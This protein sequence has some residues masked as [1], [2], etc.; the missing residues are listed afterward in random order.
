MSPRGRPVWSRLASPGRSAPVIG[1]RVAVAAFPDA[2]SPRPRPSSA[3]GRASRCMP[4]TAGHAPVR[5]R[6]TI[7]RTRLRPL[8]RSPASRRSRRADR[9][10]AWARATRKC[11][12]VRVPVDRVKPACADGRR[13]QGDPSSPGSDELSGPPTARTNPS[14]LQALLRSRGRR[15]EVSRRSRRCRAGE[16]PHH[17]NPV[18]RAHQPRPEPSDIRTARKRR[19]E[20][21]STS[22]SD[23]TG[24][25]LAGSPET[26][27]AASSASAA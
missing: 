24:G 18:R 21:R 5:T 10:T 14:P 17:R 20:C 7:A 27:S 9:P 23:E 15:R 4:R 25:E 22:N 6:R 12:C 16:C 8:G 2:Q 11:P 19:L 26:R 1:A 13:A 3:P